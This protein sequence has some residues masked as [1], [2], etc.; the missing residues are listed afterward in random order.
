MLYGAGSV[1]QLRGSP[2][3]RHCRLLYG[4]DS[5]AQLRGSPGR[6]RAGCS[7]GQAPSRNCAVALAAGTAGRPSA[8]LWDCARCG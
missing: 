6:R 7:T 1:A 3:R 4:A 2:G 5:V 8:G